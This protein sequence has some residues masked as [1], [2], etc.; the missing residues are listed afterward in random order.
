VVVE[1]GVDGVVDGVV[2][3]VGGVVVEEV[4]GVVVVVV[5][6]GRVEK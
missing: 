5:V 2:V 3:E 6:E 1:W 4:E